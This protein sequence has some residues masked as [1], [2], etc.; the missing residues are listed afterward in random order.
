MCG[1]CGIVRLDGSPVDPGVLGR[2]TDAIAHRGPDGAGTYVH[3]GV[4]LGHRRLSIIDL[5]TAAS[6]PMYSENKEL[7]LV[8][9]GEIYNF[10]DKRAMLEKRGY[11]FTSTGDSEVLLKLYQEFGEDCLQHLRGMFAFAIHDRKRNTVFV[12][13]DRVGKK[14]IKYFQVGN[15]FAFASE[16]KAL[17]TLPECPKEVDREAIHHYLT[18]MYVPSP[19][20]GIRG[21]HKLPAAHWLRIDLGSK[22]VET[23]RYW[24]LQ[25]KPDHSRSAEAWKEELGALVSESVRLRMIADV[26]VGAFLSGGVDSAAVV[27]LMARQ[28]NKPIE[29][30]SI[31]SP[32]ETHN[33]L[34]DAERIAT[35]LKTNHH[36]IVLKADIVH[37]LDELVHA[38]EEPYAD[39]SVIPTYLLARETRKS[40]TVAL[41]GDGGDENFAGYVRYPIIRF[42]ERWAKLPSPLHALVRMGTGFYHGIKQDTFSYRCH[43]FQSSIGLPWEQ[44]FLQYISFFT[45]EEKRALYAK[46]FAGN[47]PRTD[48]WY[49]ARTQGARDRGDDLIHKAMSMDIDTYLAD[50]LMPKVDLGTMAHGLESRSPLLDHE[51]L[52]FTAR[53]P[54]GLKLHGKQRKWIFKQMLQGVVPA[55]TLQ[56]KKT[57]FRLPLDR[58][59]R[60]DL[61]PFVHDR[62]MAADSPLYGMLDRGAMSKFLNAYHDSDIDYSDHLWSLLWLDAWLREYA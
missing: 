27:A 52:E 40:V 26:P 3:A 20:T 51:L 60:S 25:Y 33:E 43:R 8:F 12:A 7:T 16:M 57:G 34:P 22:K 17:R 9:N 23:G 13:R 54:S 45:E 5:S 47:F 55:E 49:A 50:D 32:E 46:G 53:I 6:Q 11:T 35:L 61:K 4:G 37:L 28:T 56:K 62:L 14:P 31:G 1:I 10:E 18:M 30:F 44:R 29:T 48:A 15:T 21:I 24:Q 36:P 58:W 19:D 2:F 41:N 59:F 42:S 39:P 38:Y